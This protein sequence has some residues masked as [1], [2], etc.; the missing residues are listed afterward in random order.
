MWPVVSGRTVV[1][2]VRRSVA[3]SDRSIVLYAGDVVSRTA[4]VSR[5]ADTGWSTSRAALRAHP[6]VPPKASTRVS[7]VKRLFIRELPLESFDA[8]IPF[9]CSHASGVMHGRNDTGAV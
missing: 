1:E 9:T 4:V 6:N 3:L 7:A 2:S 8:A 5:R